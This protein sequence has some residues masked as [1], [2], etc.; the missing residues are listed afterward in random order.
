[1]QLEMFKT[2]ATLEEKLLAGYRYDPETGEIY[3]RRR[4]WQGRLQF[5]YAIKGY[6]HTVIDGVTILRG[7]LAFLLMKGRWPVCIDHINRDRSDDRWCNLREVTHRE[8]CRNKSD[9]GLKHSNKG[10]F[11]ARVFL[12]L[13]IENQSR[14]IYFGRY[15]SSADAEK[16][17]MGAACSCFVNLLNGAGGCLFG[18]FMGAERF[19]LFAWLNAATGWQRSPEDYM[20]IGARIQTL[21][22][23]FNLRHGIRP[24]RIT[25]SDRALGRPPQTEG[26]NEGRTV[27]IEMLK[28]GYWRQMGWDPETGVP[29]KE[30]LQRLKIDVV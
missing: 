6:A 12:P 24:G 17:E 9:S 18:A 4:E 14:N 25:M 3:S 7:R 23:M 13:G 22:Q 16:A 28:K 19:P 20:Q 30:T 29:T 11:D 15:Q 21:K 10:K 27:P 1:M 2:P 5:V 26:A 8:N